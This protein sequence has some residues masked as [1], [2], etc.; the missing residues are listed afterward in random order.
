MHFKAIPLY[1][2]LLWFRSWPFQDW[3]LNSSISYCSWLLWQ[4]QLTLGCW[5]AGLLTPSRKA[6]WAEGFHQGWLALVLP[7]SKM[8][9]FLSFPVR[10][11]GRCRWVLCRQ[12]SHKGICCWRQRCVLAVILP[13]VLLCS[14][15]CARNIWQN[16]T[17]RSTWGL[18]CVCSC[19]LHCQPN[20]RNR[21]WKASS[22]QRVRVNRFPRNKWLF[23]WT[24]QTDE[25]EVLWPLSLEVG[26]LSESWRAGQHL[27]CLWEG[28]RHDT[29]GCEIREES[30][31]K[32]QN[33][34]TVA[35][36]KTESC[37]VWGKQ[38]SQ[39]LC[40]AR[41]ACALLGGSTGGSCSS[42]ASLRSRP[43]DI[44]GGGFYTG[45]SW[46]VLSPWKP[47]QTWWVLL[48]PA[49][50]CWQHQL[51]ALPLPLSLM[52]VWLFWNHLSSGSPCCPSSIATRLNPVCGHPWEYWGCDLELPK[53]G[54]APSLCQSV[55]VS[56][57]TAWWCDPSTGTSDSLGI[58]A[59]SLVS[60]ELSGT[61]RTRCPWLC[62]GTRNTLVRP[63]CVT[64]IHC[65]TFL[66][67][68]RFLWLVWSRRV[69]KIVNRI[70][71]TEVIQVW[72]NI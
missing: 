49:P 33:G 47:W 45:T 52:A 26:V 61:A 34:V 37:C 53:A 3:L 11:Q 10:R 1:P 15:F 12:R 38:W 7:A 18:V 5:A 71:T 57:G 9:S 27:L 4:Q 2:S 14:S 35:S 44:L 8:S 41:A 58:S 23:F 51:V 30:G 40:S 6:A 29:Q 70:H 63:S 55:W 28:S 50:S 19:P 21:S 69:L 59:T 65:P 42:T 39:G 72:N 31:L 54:S 32:Q 16:G 67:L 36:Q 60:Q 68:R 25:C 46:L 56:Q 43:M 66:L 62:G 24:I 48:A 22:G 64:H 13:S 17:I 20:A